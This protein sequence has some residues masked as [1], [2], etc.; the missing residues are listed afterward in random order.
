MY[1]F[2]NR[3]GLDRKYFL[4][5][6]KWLQTKVTPPLKFKLITLFRY[7]MITYQLQ[8]LL[9]SNRHFITDLRHNPTVYSSNLHANCSQPVDSTVNRPT[10]ALSHTQP[11]SCS[12]KIRPKRAP[13]SNC[14]QIR[15][16][17]VCSPLRVPIITS[18]ARNG[19][20]KRVLWFVAKST[21]P[22]DVGLEEV[23]EFSTDVWSF[24]YAYSLAGSGYRTICAA[25]FKFGGL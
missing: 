23:S 8:T 19:C 21:L 20:N 24:P 22:R 13:S 9:Q 3:G 14:T 1:F 16:S 15:K 5:F 25:I 18:I 4:V 2:G 17:P 6:Y 12:S 10:F 11:A 7:V